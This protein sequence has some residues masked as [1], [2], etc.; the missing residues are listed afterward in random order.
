MGYS[1][2]W[3]AL[4]NGTFV[5]ICAA[6]DLRPTDKREKIAE[7]AVVAA[8][9]LTGWHFIYDIPAQLAKALTG[10]RH[11]QDIPG[12]T[13]DAYQILESV[14]DVGGKQSVLTRLTSNVQR[15]KNDE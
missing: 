13:T 8:K 10:F 9:L 6:S 3:A 15:Q 4:E 14:D 11:D 12:M 5:A 1:L 7:S 2:S